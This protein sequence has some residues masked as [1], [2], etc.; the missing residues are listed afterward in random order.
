MV[1]LD[2]WEKDG[3]IDAQPQPPPP[4]G[5]ANDAFTYNQALEHHGPRGELVDRGDVKIENLDAEPDGY[6][7]KSSVNDWKRW[8]VA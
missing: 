8:R 4:P 6:R 7:S 3:G 1:T 2:S 5:R